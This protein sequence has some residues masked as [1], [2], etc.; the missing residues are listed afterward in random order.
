MA[1]CN[2]CGA[3][4]DAGAAACIWCGAGGDNGSAAAF[5]PPPMTEMPALHVAE[6]ATAPQ[7]AGEPIGAAL[8]IPHASSAAARDNLQGIGGWLILVAIGLGVDS[9]GMLFGVGA[10]FLLLIDPY[11]QK[12]LGDHHGIESQL[13]IQVA[14][15]AFLFVILLVLNFL[16]YGKRKIFPAWMISYLAAG[17]VLSFINQQMMMRFTKAF[18]SLGVFLSFVDACFWIPY[19]LCSERVKQTFVR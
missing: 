3:F 8:P 5:V 11:S 2:R 1:K 4:K 6:L 9:I 15:E 17:F 14:I 18:S 12:F 16:F 10:T 13:V 7:L 19:F